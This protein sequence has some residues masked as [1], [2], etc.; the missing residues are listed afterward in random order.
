MWLL[1]YQLREVIDYI[2]KIYRKTIRNK[3]KGIVNIFFIKLLKSLLYTDLIYNKRDMTNYSFTVTL[4]PK[5]Y[6]D[7][8]EIQYDKN[9]YDLYSLLKTLTNNFTLVV[10]LTQNMNIHMHGIIELHHK[11]KWYSAFRNSTQF[12]FTSCR[13][14]YD[15]AKWKEYISKSFIETYVTIN[16]RPIIND[17][18]EAF[19]IDDQIKYG[20]TF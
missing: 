9:V 17:D 6:G 2:L 13:E 5:M 10:E 16:R 3:N 1:V 19:T 11:K 18:Y 8:P 7:E 14:I 20:C 15:M 4:K 12:G